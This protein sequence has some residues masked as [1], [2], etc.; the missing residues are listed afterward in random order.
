MDDA[1][2]TNL[3][4]DFPSIY[5][6]AEDISQSGPYELIIKHSDGCF[7]TYSTLTRNLRRISKSHFPTDEEYAKALGRK[8]SSIAYMKGIDQVDLA[9]AL[10]VTQ[11][12]ISNYMTGRVIPS[13]PQLR[14]I[15]R[16]FNMP[17]DSIILRF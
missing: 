17:F 6:G 4:L 12:T 16:F 7:Y 11:A 8:L 10:G 13:I 1:F 14:K 9:D 3:K 2:Y 15:A 5:N